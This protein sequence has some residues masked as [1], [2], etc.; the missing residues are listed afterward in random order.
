MRPGPLE[1]AA[2]VAEAEVHA[3]TTVA[4][5]CRGWRVPARS[6]AAAVLEELGLPAGDA[7]VVRYAEGGGYAWHTDGPAR[8]ETVVIQLTDPARYDGGDVEVRLGAGEVLTAARE[9]G[10]LT[11]FPAGALHR[12][13]PVTRGERWVLVAW[14]PA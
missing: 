3:Q 6:V 9:Q 2:I 7:Q 14:T 4:V 13:T 1:C 8:A 10:A 12:A 11:R 5:E